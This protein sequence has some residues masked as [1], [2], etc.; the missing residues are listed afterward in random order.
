MV[1][2]LN[3]LFGYL[4]TEICKNKEQWVRLR[5]EDGCVKWIYFFIEKLLKLFY[6]ISKAFA[7]CHEFAK[8]RLSQ[9]KL[10]KYYFQNDY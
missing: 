9:F 10:L 8:M 6:Y 3:R 5:R 2:G 7:S 1:S 4:E